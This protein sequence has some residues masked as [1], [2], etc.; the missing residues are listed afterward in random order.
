MNKHTPAP[1]KIDTL[2]GDYLYIVS[3]QGKKWDNPVICQLYDDVTTE[4]SVTMSPWY[5][6]FE[7]AAANARLIKASPKLLD[8]LQAALMQL[9]HTNQHTPI[10][11]MQHTKD[12]IRAAIAKATGA[13]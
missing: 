1:W 7:N 3:E 6:S 8:A 5:K 4:D 9:E 11:D 2:Q 10:K 12:T 13:E